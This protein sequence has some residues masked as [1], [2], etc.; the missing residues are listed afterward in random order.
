MLLKAE[1]ISFSYPDGTK[2]L[3]RLNFE[4]SSGERVGIVAPS[5]F[6]KST[7]AKI[8]AGYIRPQ[9]GLVT[10]DGKPV[11]DGCYNPVQLIFQHPEKAVNPKWK[12][13]DIL[14]EAWTPPRELREAMGIRE[15]WMERWPTELSGGELQR[16][17]VLRALSPDTRFLIADEMTTML[18]MIT[19]AQ[20]WN[21]VLSY[22]QSNN[23]GLVVISHEQDLVDRLCQ[24][25]VY[26]DRLSAADEPAVSLRPTPH[27]RDGAAVY[28][29]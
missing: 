1:N 26:L 25:T 16:F 19:Q 12:M 14:N 11:P 13:H 28:L 27:N 10:L 5:G 24:R 15:E 29:P 17:C 8:L 4:V 21:V 7:L 2:V 6:G 20:I 22:A 9:S 3:E 23:I 18:D